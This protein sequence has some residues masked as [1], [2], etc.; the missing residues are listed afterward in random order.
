LAATPPPFPLPLASLFQSSALPSSSPSL[1][2]SDWSPFSP[3]HTLAT[4]SAIPI[5]T[6]LKTPRTPTFD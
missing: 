1:P 2:V 6:D 4:C 5:V 3:A